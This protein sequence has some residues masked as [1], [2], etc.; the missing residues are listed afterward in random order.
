MDNK[1]GY[2]LAFVG[3][4]AVGAGA[5]YFAVKDK[6]RKR[7]DEEI[8]DTR[9]YYRNK[10]SSREELNKRVEDIK[11][12]GELIRET[13][14]KFEKAITP[15]N[16]FSDED[17]KEKYLATLESPKEDPHV[18]DI[19]ADD[20]I[21]GALTYDKISLRVFIED[22]TVVDENDEPVIGDDLIGIENLNRILDGT[23]DGLYLRDDER[24]IDYEVDKADGA[25]TDLVGEI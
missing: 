10:Y 5:A 13:Q 8:K 25:Y 14:K 19:S 16:T 21:N 22:G 20:F 12:E 7:A 18:Y 2:I 6:E 9:E 11:A 17:E 23:E 24:M 15:Y 1:L 3:G 4:A